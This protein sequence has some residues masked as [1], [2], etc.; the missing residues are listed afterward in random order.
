[1]KPGDKN[2][3]FDPARKGQET[4]GHVGNLLMKIISPLRH[5]RI[6]H[7]VQQTKDYR[8]IVRRKTPKDVFLSADL[9][10]VQAV[11]IYV[12]YATQFARAD[13][14]FE[15]QHRRVIPK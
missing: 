14:F 11:R 7:L 12:L 8:N 9:T 1:M 6:R 3:G 15:L 5:D 10:Q 13:Q 2:M 4:D